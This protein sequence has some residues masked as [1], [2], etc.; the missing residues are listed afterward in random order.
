MD[1]IEVSVKTTSEAYEAISDILMG[2]GAQGI[3]IDDPNNLTFLDDESFVWDYIDESI[4]KNADDSVR[5][6][7][8]YPKDDT[9]DKKIETIKA[10]IE[11]ARQYLDVGDGTIELKNVNNQD[12]ENEWKKNYSPFRIGSNILIKPSWENAQVRQSDIVIELDP[13]MAFGTGTH[14]TTS[15][16]VEFLEK[17]IKKNDSLLDIGCGSGI[18]SIVGAKL[19]CSKVFAIDIDPVAVNVTIENI[20]INNVEPIVKTKKALVEEIEKEKYQVIVANIVADA[21]MSIS[22]TVK[23]F[24]DEQS[25]YIISGIIKERAAKVRELLVKSGFVIIEEKKIGEWV[26]MVLKCQSSL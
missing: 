16:C 10:S 24:M 6:I 18:L 2:Q 21:I 19:G 25:I 22:P 12:W 7:A 11:N 9:A 3:S 17:Y 14:E 13:G 1:W 15:M 5:V 4:A 23:S 20:R 26:A 8:Y